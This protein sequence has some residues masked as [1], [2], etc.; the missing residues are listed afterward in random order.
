MLI[1]HYQAARKAAAVAEKDW[2][3]IL[4]LTG[5]ERSSWLQGMVTNDVQKLTPGA[6]CYA[7][8]LT[9]QG[10]IVAHMHILA[11][12]D[13]L[14]LLLER[15]AIPKLRDAFDKLLIME[16]VQITDASGEYNILAVIGPKARSVLESWLGEPL[17]IDGLYRHRKFEGGRLFES[18]LGYDLWIPR[19]QGDKV[20]RALAV[21]GATA[22]DRGTWDVLRTEAGMPVFGIDIDETTTMPEIGERGISYEKGCYIGQEVVAK[23]K[24]IGHV[25]RRFVGLTFA[26]NDL[27]K[28][29]SPI[30]KGGKEV[31]YVTTSLLSPGLNKPVALGF[32][33]RAAYAAG[34]E[35][36]VVGEKTLAATIVD[37]PFVK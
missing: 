14:W 26:G 29:K 23:V 32:V 21:S 31:G 18:D 22:I 35:V 34:T 11:D 7:A 5:S 4:K 12:D 28:L 24:Y 30:R 2:F 20:L 27:P 19:E 33:S 25:N 10:K 13:T 17:S 6:G 8:H 3:G 15:A 16:D 9:P 1:E 37:L 36:E